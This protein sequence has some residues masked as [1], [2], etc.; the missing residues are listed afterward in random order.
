VAIEKFE[1]ASVAKMDMGRIRSA[2]DREMRLAREDCVDRPALKKARKVILVATL[3]PSDGEDAELID[4]QF[5]I[6]H[7]LPRRTSRPYQM[8]VA[9]GRMLFNDLSPDDVAQMT[10]D[11]VGPRSTRGDE[12]DAGV[13][14][15]Q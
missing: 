15:A 3:T 2:W 1:L 6:D 10:L 8:Q 5:E 12:D 4:V 11:E 9:R 7:K 14:R 13:S